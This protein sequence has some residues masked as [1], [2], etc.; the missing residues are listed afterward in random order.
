MAD[1]EIPI[2]LINQF[3]KNIVFETKRNICGSGGY[4]NGKTYAGCLKILILSA[5]FPKYRTAI[6]RKEYKVLRQTTMKTWFKICPEAFIARHSENDGYTRLKNGSEIIWLNLDKFDEQSLKS[7]EINSALLDQAEEIDENIH[8]HLDTRI[9]R[10]DMAEIPPALLAANPNWPKNKVTNLYLAPSY[11]IALC[12]PETQWHY[13]YR[14]YHPESSIWAKKYSKTHVMYQAASTD[15]P[16]LSQ[17]TLDVMLSKDPEWVERY[18]KGIW[19]I[20]SA[21]IHHVLP[22]SILEYNEELLQ[23]LKSKGL[24]YRTLDHGEKS[25]TCCLWFVTWR[26]LIFCVREYYVPD[27]LIS[28]HRESINSLSNEYYA[29][30]FADP[31]IFKKQAQK[32]GGR[33]CVADEYSDPSLCPASP[34][35]WMAADN[36]EYHTRNRISELLQ[37]DKD[38]RHPI[39]GEPNSPKLYFIKKSN[40]Y[41]H[42]C[43]NV[44][45]ET[46][47]QRRSKLGEVDGKVIYGDEREDGLPDHAYDPLRY[48]IAIHA[49]RQKVEHHRIKPNSF[50]AAQR[51][52]K[53]L[54]RMGVYN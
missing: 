37:L 19:G 21:T 36:N 43:D 27:R 51:N 53:K 35:T 15:N 8:T 39:T 23:N 32:K 34:I 46:S 18:V 3:Q 33:F 41:P 14:L 1:L 28:H 45:S 49:K 42:G 20:S 17:E 30:S 10:W 2:Q 25:P 5:T 12:N 54:I 40:E 22:Q 38:V 48:F 44:I 24:W 26:G 11:M 13:L 29:G 7:L 4:G 50:K 47:L 31:S 6:V 16:A 52:I 9:G